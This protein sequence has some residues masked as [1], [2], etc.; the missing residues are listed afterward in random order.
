M[1][2]QE[3]ETI[4][5]LRLASSITVSMGGWDILLPPRSNKVVRRKVGVDEDRFL[6]K[7]AT[8]LKKENKVKW[9]LIREK[10][11]EEREIK[12][13]IGQIGRGFLDCNN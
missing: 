4:K 7:K 8:G 6:W 2:K 1:A 5:K 11:I 9:E 13:R 12:K 3:I 10:R